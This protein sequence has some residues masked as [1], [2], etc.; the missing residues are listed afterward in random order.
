[1]RSE[2]RGRCRCC[3]ESE[4]ARVSQGVLRSEH[5]RGGSAMAGWKGRAAARRV[6][7]SDAELIRRSLDGDTEAFM[8]V[9][10]RHEGALGAY[11]VRRVGRAAAED[12]LG[13]V[14]VAAFES[15]RTYDQSFAD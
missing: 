8:E 9:I 6:M 11:L 10:G 7:T 12:L 1:M 14:W 4:H 15:R 2:G 3:L 13:E 5:F